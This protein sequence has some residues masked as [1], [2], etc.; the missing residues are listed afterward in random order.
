[1]P[2][3]TD[4]WMGHETPH[5]NPGGGWVGR[6]KLIVYQCALP[7]M[8]GGLELGFRLE[9]YNPHGSLTC[10]IQHEME[11]HSH[12]SEALGLKLSCA[13]HP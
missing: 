13:Y 11:A 9:A 5:Q 2:T 3:K 8:M 12:Q 4:G 10:W 1:M 7:P 6:Q